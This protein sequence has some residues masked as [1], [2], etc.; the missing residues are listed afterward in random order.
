MIKGMKNEP[1]YT[2]KPAESFLS[3]SVLNHLRMETGIG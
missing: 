2:G 3:N 1:K